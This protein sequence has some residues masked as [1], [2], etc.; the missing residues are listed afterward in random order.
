MLLVASANGSVGM[1]AGWEILISG[2]A[3]LDAVEAAARMVEDNP[4]DHSVGYD[5]YPNLLGVVELDASLMDGATR[6][7]GAVGAVRGYRHP[8]TIARAVLD[9]LPHVMV[10]GEG[11]ERL[12]SELGMEREELLTDATKQVWRDGVEGH[13][14]P[15]DSRR[16]LL[17]RVSSLF[18]ARSMWQGR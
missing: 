15:A 6:R 18:A 13:L 3:A 7:A 9:R 12:A 16:R 2:G 14:D 17:D 11:A 8:I 5:G 4:D 10:V 1:D